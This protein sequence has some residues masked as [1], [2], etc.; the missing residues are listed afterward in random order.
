MKV[1]ELMQSDVKAITGDASVADAIVSLAD[2]HVHGLP[3]VQ[4]PGNR[5]IGV[6][7]NTDILEAFTECES[8]EDRDRLLEAT[9]VSDLM[10]PNPTTIKPDA[11]VTEAAQI[12]LYREIHRLFVVDGVE[13]VGVISQSDIVRAVGTARL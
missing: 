2:A 1:A 10:T 4:G 3:V 11:D 6:L 12:M 9:I 5:L 8:S 13:L 7:S